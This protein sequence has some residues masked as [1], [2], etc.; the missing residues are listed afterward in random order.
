MNVQRVLQ[1]LVES[2]RVK[3]R[4]TMAVG[5]LLA[6]DLVVAVAAYVPLSRDVARREREKIDVL[7]RAAEAHAQFEAQRSTAETL[8]RNRVNAAEFRNERLGTREERYLGVKKTVETFAEVGAPGAGPMS[9]RASVVEPGFLLHSTSLNID[10]SYTKLRQVLGQIQHT[11]EFLMVDRIAFTLSKAQPTAR[12]EVSTAYTLAR[13]EPPPVPAGLAVPAAAAG[14]AAAGPADDEAARV[15]AQA[16]AKHAAALAAARK[17]AQPDRRK[18]PKGEPAR[19]GTGPD[20][21][22]ARQGAERTPPAEP[23]ANTG[24]PAA[25]GKPAR[26]PAKAPTEPAPEE[27]R[28]SEERPLHAGGP[29]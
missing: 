18:P 24:K 26:T 5:A 10:G 14:G 16:Q 15:A 28:P 27:E 8:Y 3:R 25:P 1:D 13:V 11:T 21:P 19:P 6:V 7:Q 4:V 23:T 20:R 17:G 29:R 9:F 12:I 2:A 22:G